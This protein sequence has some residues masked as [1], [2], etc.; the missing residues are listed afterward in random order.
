MK[1]GWSLALITVGA[2]FAF[3]VHVN[4]PG[5]DLNIVGVILV[6]VGIAGHVLSPDWE[7]TR[8]RL[9][10][11]Y[12][13]ATARP[14]SAV[15]MP[16]PAVPPQLPP[17]TTLPSATPSTPPYAAPPTPPPTAPAAPAAAPPAAPPYGQS[18]TSYI[19]TRVPNPRYTQR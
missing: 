10:V 17:A 11:V 9:I 6:L 3:A 7:S 12:R 5:L 4:T 15:V 1:L 2:I 14:R 8:R 16:T 19:D 13:R 18:G